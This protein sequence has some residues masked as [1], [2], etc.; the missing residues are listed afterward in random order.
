MTIAELNAQGLLEY[1]PFP[2][3]LKDKYQSFTEANLSALRAAGYSAPFADVQTGVSRYV[4]WLL[5][6][7]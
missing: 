5:N 4:K 7:R 1:T 3:A 6:N 2:P